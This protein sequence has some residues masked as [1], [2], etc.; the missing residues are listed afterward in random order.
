MVCETTLLTILLQY[1]YTYIYGST[2][3]VSAIN[4]NEI[5]A[6]AIN[7]NKHEKKTKHNNKKK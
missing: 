2:L 5:Q 7:K 4:D 6:K 3:N 1:I